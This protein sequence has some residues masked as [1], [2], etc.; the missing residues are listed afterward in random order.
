MAVHTATPAIRDDM[1]DEDYRREGILI[2]KFHPL[3]PEDHARAETDSL[4]AKACGKGT[5]FSRI[6]EADRR[7]AI[8][9]EKQ[10][11]IARASHI[12]IDNKVSTLIDIRSQ[13]PST[14]R[15]KAKLNNNYLTPDEYGIFRDPEVYAR[16]IDGYALQVSREDIADILQMANG[17]ENLFMQQRNNPSHQQRV[18]SEIYNTTSGV[19]DRFKQ[20]SRHHNRPSIDVEVS[21]SIDRR[22]EFGKR[23]YDRDG[24]R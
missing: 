1:F 23:A 8:D 4:F 19:D 20:K 15:E 13:P 14:L 5:R 12:S 16:A 17:A 6:S 21:S 24:E 18:T 3:K 9:T 22:P 11:L 2:Y 7:A 10:K